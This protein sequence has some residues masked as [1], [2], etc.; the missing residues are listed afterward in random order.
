MI[1]VVIL[2]NTNRSKMADV[3]KSSEQVFI[4]GVGMTK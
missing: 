2:I 3:R 1:H 4:V